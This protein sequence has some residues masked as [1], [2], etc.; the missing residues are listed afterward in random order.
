MREEFWWK[1]SKTPIDM[2]YKQLKLWFDEELAA[3]LADKLIDIFPSFHIASFIQDI[4]AQLPPLE[5][6]DRI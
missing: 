4:S 1:V 3:L 5:L 2:A 6:K